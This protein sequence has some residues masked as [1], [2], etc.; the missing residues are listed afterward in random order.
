MAVAVKGRD[1]GLS[2]ITG[3]L[4]VSFVLGGAI[5][6]EKFNVVLQRVLGFLTN[7]FGW[8]F[9]LF[10]LGF[11]LTCLLLAF[12]YG[13]VKLGRPEDKPEY[14]RFS[15]FAMLFSAGMGIGLMFWSVAEPL[16]HF[17]K[18]PFGKPYSDEAVQV[19]MRYTFFHWGIHAWAVYGIVGLALAYFGFRK[20]APM[21][22][23]SV[24]Q[25]LLG[26]R[27][28]GWIGK[29]LDGLAV[30][31][32]IF[33]VAT[34][35]GLGTMQINSGLKY[36]FG[37]PNSTWTNVIIV[38]IIT[39]MFTLSAISGI[40]RGI[41]ILSNLNVV[42]AVV[43]LIFMFLVG[44][45]QF[46]VNLTTDTVGDY[47]Q[48]FFSMSLD[49][50]PV[51]QTGWVNSWTVFYWAWWIA[52][53]PFVG[54]FIAR[55][56]RGRTIREFVLG[57]LIAP[58]IFSFLWMGV[59]G[60]TAL[61]LAITGQPNIVDPVLK[62]IG[63]GLFEVFRYYPLS[64]FLSGLALLL[65]TTFFVTSADSATFVVGILLSQ[66]HL[67][68]A[69]GTKIFWG[70]VQGAIAVVLLLT[71]GLMALQTASIIAAFPFMFVM[72]AMIYVLFHELK[73]ISKEKAEV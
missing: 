47:I 15:W 18:P 55:I 29:S 46:I 3:V 57:V 53:A 34:S 30:F 28:Q 19:A 63:S 38:G 39:V 1:Y 35:L 73:S 37:I 67:E 24:F 72:A 31:A 62:D 8:M 64:G 26:D 13:D 59:F 49:T 68:P 40:G 32:T 25:P 60:G 54:G 23:S 36:L 9:L 5:Y 51:R 56:S 21:L 66:G 27:T 2:V 12:K 4:A 43:L 65:I 48:N 69:A 17:S 52:W 58:V 44:P 22:I 50:D 20:Q 70:V 10:V 16:S 71:G 14:S 41:R 42:L 11:V 6:P 7:W 33:G 45:S 61:H